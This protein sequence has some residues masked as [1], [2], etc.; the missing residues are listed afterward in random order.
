M[1]AALVGAVLHTINFRLF[2]EQI[3]Y[4]V[5]LDGVAIYDI[6]TGIMSERVWAM[7]GKATASSANA[8][9]WEGARFFNV[10][11]L[12]LLHPDAVVTLGETR[13]VAPPGKRNSELPRWV[14]LD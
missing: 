1:R 5:S 12:Q 8:D 7:R 3:S 6:E 10:G 14:P 2:P 9:G 11:R 13:R 4:I